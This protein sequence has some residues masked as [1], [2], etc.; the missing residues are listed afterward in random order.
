MNQRNIDSELYSRFPLYGWI[1]PCSQ[2]GQPAFNESSNGFVCQQCITKNKDFR[3]SMYE[4]KLMK[5]NDINQL[6]ECKPN[7]P[8]LKQLSLSLNKIMPYSN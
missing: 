8:F 6:K 1:F 4:K 7:P 2:C 5:Q 3:T